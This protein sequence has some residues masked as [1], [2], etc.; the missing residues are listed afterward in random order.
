MTLS[1]HL[2]PPIFFAGASVSCIQ[3][4]ASAGSA[5]FS[6]NLQEM[7]PVTMHSLSLP[8]Y[9]IQ[10]TGSCSH[11]ITLTQT[12]V[13]LFSQENDSRMHSTKGL[14]RSIYYP[15]KFGSH[16]Q[17]LETSRTEIGKKCL[18]KHYISKFVSISVLRQM[19]N[20]EARN[21]PNRYKS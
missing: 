6:W 2:E 15:M 16:D 13:A 19:K 12:V 10:D 8:A 11:T 9:W 17:I 5:W 14:D 20:Q 7:F 3:Y 1:L 18:K 21:R 4:E